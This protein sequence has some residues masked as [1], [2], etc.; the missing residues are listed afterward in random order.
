[1]IVQRNWRGKLGRKRFKRHIRY[2]DLR[3][4]VKKE[5]EYFEMEK[6][7]QHS[8][9]MEIAHKAAAKMQGLY[10][11]KQGR[12]IAY[13]ARQQMVIKR[14]L[15]RQIDMENQIKEHERLVSLFH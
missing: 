4:F 14:A 3:E 11:G 8:R 13:V 15:Q 10:R 7:D 12:H 1:M 6:E 5:Y 2:R 9:I